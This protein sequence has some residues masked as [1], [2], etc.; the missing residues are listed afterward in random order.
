MQN[1]GELDE[2]F[3]ITAKYATYINNNVIEP[4]HLLYV[5]INKDSYSHGNKSLSNA[6][7]K[8]KI[9]VFL[10]NLD[11]AIG[12]FYKVQSN[13]LSQTGSRLQKI[14][15]MA[16]SLANQ[17]QD[18]A[19]N[20]D[21]IIIS[22]LHDPQILEILN[23]S[24]INKDEII[25][26]IVSR[27][28]GDTDISD[29][30]T[31][32]VEQARNGEFDPVIGR[33]E[34]IRL[35]IEI[36][37]KKSKANPLL[38][39]L[40]GVGK[41][42][43][44]NGL[45]QLIADDKIPTL[46]DFKIYN[47]DVGSLVANT[48]YRGQFEER[49]KSLVK[50]IESDDKSILFVDEFHTMVSAGA[51]N[52]GSL[53][54]TNMLKPSLAS[55]KIKCI[56]ATTFYEYRKYIENDQALVRRFV[57]INVPEPTISDGITILRGLRE[58]FEA[59]HGVKISDD[60]LVFAVKSSK[61]YISNRRLP[62][63]AIDLVDSAC[64][65][66]IVNLENESQPVTMLKEQMWSVELEIKALEIDYEREKTDILAARINDL[67]IH[68]ENLK[69]ELIPLEESYNEE[70]KNITELKNLKQKLE[71]YNKKLADAE[72]V[73]DHYTA[74]EI[75]HEILPH[76]HKKISEL[77]S[78]KAVV[79]SKDIAEIIS[80]LTR[81]P[82]TRLTIQENERLLNMPNRLKKRVFGQDSAIDNIVQA[83]TRSRLSLSDPNKPIGS[84]LLLGP[85]G[86]G[87]TELAKA[88]AF[89]LFDDDKNMVI[90]DM[91]DYMNEMSVTKLVG[92]SAGYI[93]Y[94]EGGTLTEPIKNKPYNVILMDEV[95]LANK[96]ILNILYQLLDE[97]R[98]IDGKRNQID[99]TNTVIIMTSNIG[100][101]E[102]L[103]K[104][105][106]SNNLNENI[107]V[108]EENILNEK[109]EKEL[110]STFGHALVNRIDSIIQFNPLS[111]DTLDMI[112]NYQIKDINKR[113][114]DKNITIN[115]NDSVKKDIISHSYSYEY[116]ARPL[117][118]NIE[119]I[120]VS[121][122]TEIILKI[123]VS[124]E[125]ADIYCSNEEI[126]EELNNLGKDIIPL[127]IGK[128]NYHVLIK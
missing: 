29:F 9:P 25:S 51:S 112:F 118:R 34:E 78:I 13:L 74:L 75:K 77:E 35:M 123:N 71:K 44:I 127:T 116:G 91:S 111:L 58:R 2:L 30:A 87:K 113:L 76:I 122:I 85:T 102:I 52:E 126:N 5:L 108:T 11:L 27:P 101:Y 107:N 120:L 32:M 124:K 46:K 31:E 22:S 86:T 60:A 4:E 92:A 66:A 72:K 47:L 12:N 33:V 15:Q 53:D 106:Q 67:K 36:L 89:E 21:H 104:Y 128:Y 3:Q 95:N 69:N 80:R 70:K 119:K 82:V 16:E 65:S 88:L 43:I 68:L 115:V 84:F 59:H 100:E 93:G 96:K 114:K 99:F 7:P 79:T 26:K 42:A 61:K 48:Q 63:I 40:P 38:V 56:G 8:D 18:T 23:R 83:I 55:G 1:T 103:Q 17:M 54:C 90:L 57:K 41:S 14:Q 45:A 19:I 37:S 64:S 97:G 28:K 10:K 105:N 121:A 24:N 94:E 50:Q 117:K 73:R 109:I 98:V 39:G 81:I 49:F 62:D 125:G 20:S 110:I 6:I